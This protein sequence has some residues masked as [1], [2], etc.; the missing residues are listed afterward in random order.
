MNEES[1]EFTAMNPKVKECVCASKYQDERYGMSMRLMNPCKSKD[2]K[3]TA[4]RCTVCR[5]EHK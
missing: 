5:R 4:Y 3:T 1:K 2:D